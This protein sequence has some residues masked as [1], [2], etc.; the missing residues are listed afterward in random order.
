M[1]LEQTLGSPLGLESVRGQLLLHPSP[2]G[3]L[4]AQRS[5]RQV[6]V[7]A[8]TQQTS[9]ACQQ[10]REDTEIYSHLVLAPWALPVSREVGHG[11]R[12]QQH[13]V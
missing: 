11:H 5:K 9:S 12:W 7:C 2:L 1:G 8:F 10:C 4:P 6:Q 3:F 13:K